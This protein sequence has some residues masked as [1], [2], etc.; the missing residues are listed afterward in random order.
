MTGSIT[1][2]VQGRPVPKGRPRVVRGRAYTPRETVI[3]ERKIASIA[4]SAWR[5]PLVGPVVVEAD[6]RFAD[7][8]SRGDVDNL[9]KLVLDA[10]IGLA[11]ADDRQVVELHATVVRADAAATAITVSPAPPPKDGP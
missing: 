5:Q 11:Y 9:V 3:A 7:S 6:F 1:I 8:R 2:V 4:R 10:L